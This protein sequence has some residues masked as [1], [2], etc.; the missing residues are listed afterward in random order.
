MVESAVIA[1]EVS[2]NGFLKN[3]DSARLNGDEELF[4]R[5]WLRLDLEYKPDV[6]KL[7]ASLDFIND[8]LSDVNVFKQRLREA[9]I[10]FPVG[11]VDLKVGKQQIVWGKADGIFITDIVNPFDFRDNFLVYDFPDMRIGLNS[12]K[13]TYYYQDTGLELVWIPTFV[14]HQLAPP[15]EPW[16]FAFPETLIN[17][18]IK[19][20]VL[21]DNSLSNS[22][23]G[24]RLLTRL[25]GF[26]VTLNYLHVWDDVPALHKR[27]G[28][29]IKVTPQF[30][31][32][33]VPGY[34]VANAFGSFVVRSEGALFLERFFD[35]INLTKDGGLAKKP[36]LIY[37]L[38]A[39]YRISE[40]WLLL[41][42]FIQ[43][44]IFDYDEPI[45]QDHVQNSVTLRLSAELL[46]NSLTPTIFM[47]YNFHDND[48]WFWPKVTYKILDGLNGTIG[49]HIFGGD[50]QELFGQF[51]E[52]DYAYF[53]VQYSF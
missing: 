21:P 12:V 48:I 37:M 2:I 35:T 10:D 14:P 15:G 40:N 42:Q 13:A 4:R 26:D 7:Y 30:Y 49:A 44:I 16:A 41:G 39:D 36:Y 8:N 25:K 31:R 22:E 46:D 24:A 3:Y 33:H 1:D 32:L 53:E 9:Y 45:L 27:I 20:S 6:A 34:S 23:V 52:N 43:S 28:P 17:P 11:P 5:N 47:F 19:P 51:N 18:I 29:G 50:K 38:G